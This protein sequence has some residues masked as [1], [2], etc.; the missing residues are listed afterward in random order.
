MLVRPFLVPFVLHFGLIAGLYIWLTLARG[1]AVGRG[2]AEYS[3]FHRADGDPPAV[4]PIARNLS[5]QFELPTLAWFCAALLIFMGAV[6]W[7]DVSAAWVFLAGRLIH[8]FVQ[9]LTQNVALR[10]MV[11][12][13]NAA[14]VFW[15]AAHVAWIV[16]FP[17]LR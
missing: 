7:L 5:N 1:R 6:G 17:D 13:I 11:F 10:G 14:G 8:T 3:D 2:E 4:A 16:A 9:T 15:L 12:L